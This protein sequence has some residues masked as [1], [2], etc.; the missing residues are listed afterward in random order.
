MSNVPEEVKKV[1]KE[2]GETAESAGWVHKQ[3][4]QWI[5]SHKALERVAARKNIKF[6]APVIVESHINDKSVAIVVTGHLGDQTQW[7][8]GEAADYNNKMGYPFAMAEKRAKD[9]VILKLVGLHGYVYS[10]DEA[11][12]FKESKPEDFK[13]VPGDFISPEQALEITNLMTAT[14][15]TKEQFCK[16]FEVESVDRLPSDD[17]DRA[18]IMLNERLTKQKATA[19]RSEAINKGQWG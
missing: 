10:E 7:S 13:D 16:R 1:L 9:R 2:L 5:V 12:E 19:Q 8:F 14:K 4:K 11:E 18:K 6:D 15:V 3:S 17:F